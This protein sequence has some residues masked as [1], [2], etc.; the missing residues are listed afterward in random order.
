MKN[1]ITKFLDDHK[2]IN[3]LVSYGLIKEI[4]YA[5]Y[6]TEERFYVLD[7]Q[8]IIVWEYC[9]GQFAGI[10]TCSVPDYKSLLA[11]MVTGVD[12]LEIVRF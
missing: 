4:T 6:G 12:A 8:K 5:R 2:D 7:S 1:T 9:C 10:T 3:S 11:K